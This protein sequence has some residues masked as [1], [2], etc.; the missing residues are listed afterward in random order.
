M[1]KNKL[2]NGFLLALSLSVF[3]VSCSDDDGDKTSAGFAGI[4][5]TFYEGSGDATVTIPIVNGNVS[6]SDLVFDGTATEGE[7]YEVLGVTDE[8]VQIKFID[9]SDC[10]GIETVRIRITGKSSNANVIHTATI[11]SGDETFTTEEM[12]GTYTVVTDTWVDFL[13]GDELTVERV[14]A[15]HI[16]V[17]EYPATG[18]SHQPMVITIDDLTSGAAR[19]ETQASG[20]YNASGTQSTTTTG[21]GFASK[22]G[23]IDLTLVFSLGGSSQYHLVLE[24]AE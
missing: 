5:S 15:T 3:A 12:V 1:K 10:E 8:G 17:V 11:I 14:D 13:P 24:K 18:F 6:E 20:S 19:V 23:G 2:I 7:D 16:R 21:T 22:C 9:D 4:A